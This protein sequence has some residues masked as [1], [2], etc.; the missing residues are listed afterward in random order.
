MLTQQIEH[1][2][3]RLAFVAVAVA[4]L[5]MKPFRHFEIIGPCEPK[6][7]CPDRQPGSPAG[8]PGTACDRNPIIGSRQ[9]A[10]TP[11]P[12]TRISRTA[13]PPGPSHPARHPTTTL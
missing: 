7:K 13:T 2:L 5:G 1:R 10:Y 8:W 11:R 4:G 9:T 3:G 12:G 6:I